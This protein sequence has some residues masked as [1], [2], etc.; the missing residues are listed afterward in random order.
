MPC[1]TQAGAD[2][3]PRR[4]AARRISRAW[5]KS[6]STSWWSADMACARRPISMHCSPRRWPRCRGWPTIAPPTWWPVI[7]G[8]FATR[9][10]SA[11]SMRFG[12]RHGWRSDGHD[13]DAPLRRLARADGGRRRSVARGQRRRAGACT[14]H[15]ALFPR[16]PQCRGNSRTAG[17]GRALEH[18]SATGRAGR[19][20]PRRPRVRVD[21]NAA[22]AGAARRCARAHRVGRLWQ[23]HGQRVEK[24]R[25]RQK[26]AKRRAASSPRPRNWASPYSTSPVC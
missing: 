1:T 5:A 25:L 7:G 20:P 8:Q 3:F 15:R 11:L 10:S 24:D 17:G 18:A 16:G 21:G 14:K 26:P 23:G 19:G 6:S 4:R 2:P 22:D 12:I 13:L 9:R